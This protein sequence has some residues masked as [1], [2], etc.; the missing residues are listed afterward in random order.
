MHMTDREYIY[1]DTN[2]QSYVP[3]EEGHAEPG[4]RRTHW[5]PRLEITHIAGT[6]QVGIVPPSDKSTDDGGLWD[7]NDG[8]FMCLSRDGINRAIR[9][10]R[11]YRDAAYGRDE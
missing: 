2:G 4:Q 11:E 10:L 1:G 5:D 9:A 6:V 3:Y 8:R 7:P